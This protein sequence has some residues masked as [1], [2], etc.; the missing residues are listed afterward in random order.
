MFR[1]AFKIHESEQT[2]DKQSL[3]L[4]NRETRTIVDRFILRGPKGG[5]I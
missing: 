2:M 5:Q 4:S 3:R 1:F